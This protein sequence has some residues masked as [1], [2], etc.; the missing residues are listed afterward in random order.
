MHC[1]SK[2]SLQAS[3]PVCCLLQ[4]TDWGQISGRWTTPHPHSRLQRH[5]A[6]PPP[7]AHPHSSR[8]E[9]LDTWAQTWN[10]KCTWGCWQQLVCV[11]Q[12]RAP[13]CCRIKVTPPPHLS[14]DWRMELQTTLGE[15]LRRFRNHRVSTQYLFSISILIFGNLHTY[16]Y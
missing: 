5:R 12:P 15:C 9:T 1:Q 3:V 6:Q 8:V 2:C 14:P 10:E 7:T 13:V 16:P 11:C 4:A